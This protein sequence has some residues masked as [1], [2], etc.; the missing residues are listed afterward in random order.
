MR[1]STITRTWLAGLAGIVAGV[2]GAGLGTVLLL[3]Y[4]GTWTGY[5]DPTG[6]DFVPTIDAFFWWTVGLICAGA[7]VAVAGVVAQ[8]VAWIGALINT[9]AS[10]DKTWFV[11]LLTGGLLSILG[12]MIAPFLV[13]VVYVLSGPDVEPRVTAGPPATLAPAS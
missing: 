5:G 9:F 2:I 13:M 7:L 4:G 3:A 1:K 6:G 11:V 10:A 8:V 12:L